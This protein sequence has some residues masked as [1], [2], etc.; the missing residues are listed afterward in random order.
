MRLST[1]ARRLLAGLLPGVLLLSASVALSGTAAA[2]DTTVSSDTLR[3]GWDQN[4]PGLAPSSVTAADFGQ[5]FSTPVNGQVYAQPI[6][7]AGTVITV[8]ENNWIYGMNAA[9]GAITWSRS[10]GAPWPASAIGCGDL[11]PNIGI[12]ST[13]VYDPASNSVF[14]IA[15]VNDGPDVNNPHFYLHSVNPATGVER[16][17]WPVTIQGSPTNSPGNPF[18][19]K[20]A[21]Q[22]PGLLLLGGV[23]YAGFASHCDYGPYA[24]YVAGFSTTTPTMT[25]LWS[26]EAGS[27]SGMAGIW[28]S[29]GG[30]VSDGPGRILLTTGNG[31]SPAPGP[32]TS[33]PGNLGES[34]VRL[35]VNSD[36]SLTAKDFFSP[37]NNAMLDQNDTDF[38][39]GGPMALPAGFGTTAHPNLLVQTGKDGR[40]YL[41]DRDNLGGNAQGPGGTDASVGPPAGPYNGVWGHPAFWGGDGGYVYQ[42]ENAG[43]L[44]AFKYGVNGSGLPVLSSA[45][46]SASTFGYTSG[47]P[48]V[49]STGTTSGSAVVWVVYSDGS[50]GANGQLRAYNAVP[51]NGQLTLLYS[52]PIGTASKFAVPGTDGNRVYV[53]TRDGNVYGFGQ[54]TTAALTGSPT[55]FGNVAVKS[56]ANA[57]VTVTATRTVT[58]SA[59]TASAPFG[60]T[61][62]ALPVTLTSG[63][64]LSVPV[65]FTPTAAG[66]ANGTLSFTTNS[67]TVPFDLH[68][69][70][71]Q[72]GLGATP[73][74]LPFGTV[75]TG[76]N[77]ALSVSIANT[78]T[79]PVTITGSTAPTAPFTVTGLP[80]NGST[81]AAGA[82]VSVTVTYAPTAVGN[83]SGS[84]VVASSAGSVT[85]PLTGTAVAGASHLT[86]TPN[87]V[88]FGSVALGQSATQIFDIAN[89]GNI[90]LT[91]TKAAPPVGVFNTTTP[92]SEGQKLAPGD[93]IQQSVTFSPTTAGAQ[94][95]VYSITG[96]DGQ[97]AIAV[98]LTGTGA[99]SGIGTTNI[100]AGEPATASGTQSGYPAGNATDADVNSYWESVNNAFPQWLQVDLGAANTVGKVTLQV[101]PATA[102]TT[103]TQTLSILGST[104]GTNFT[105]LVPST[106]Y[107]FNPAT[108]N[109]VD[110]LFGPSTVRYLRLSF[111]ANTG[112]PAGQISSFE[113]F[114]TISGTGPATL[115]TSPASLTFAATPVQNNSDWQTVTVT[116]TG[117][118][119]ATLSSIATSGDFTV[120]STCGT[121]LAPGA[122]CVAVVT[123]YPTAAGTRTGA[124]TITGNAT[125]SPTTV[126]LSG[127][128]IATGSA[129]LSANPVSMA[130]ASTTVGSVSAAST[131]TITNTGTVSASVSAVAATAQF[132][133]TNNCA[134][135]APGSSCTVNVTFNPT[136]AGNVTGSLTVTSNATNSPLTVAL[137]GTGTGNTNPTNLAPAGT[138]SA[139]NYT[140]TYAPGNANDNNTSTY[141]EGTNGVWPTTLTCNLGA[142]HSL[143][144]LVIDLPPATAWNTRTQ[145]LSVLGS[146]N[147]SSYTTL[148]GSATYTFNPATG[149]TVTISLPTG[150][151]AQYV[152]L[153]FTAN[154]VQNGAQASEFQVWGN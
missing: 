96:D 20:T 48:V 53:G 22:R 138:M 137:S 154:S 3:T 27:S 85:V 101:P 23:V 124:L 56:T 5:L 57:T 33:P 41:L 43:Y 18:N 46:T 84:L 90:T 6:V 70:G 77:A 126:A 89:T 15:K 117:T 149:N 109:S 100:A 13:P 14:F 105:V 93:I 147:G 11:T 12:T 40:V 132:A 52:A 67:G 120:G 65:Q 31:V 141:W 32:G 58:I 2:D 66:G 44:R 38:G 129:T 9:T 59:I 82:S 71:T 116:N 69:I 108:G 75:S 99:T 81:L 150:T 102:W 92:I 37:S 107:T 114:P 131:V 21:A 16:A 87:P 39:S 119:P 51:V 1:R 60:V 146:S 134:S 111:T 121:S 25:T 133:Q 112:W 86:I 153:S 42:V 152:Q 151:T 64:T 125:N 142:S 97:G 98:Q 24:G 68:G 4:E 143:S 45:G 80:A 145:T 144:S 122:N 95:A 7:V 127:S 118:G 103:R 78:G 28:Q 73:A 130:F 128:G 26:T 47:S 50:T 74:S 148:V 123:F 135:L 62:P 115:S 63:G 30:L 140:Q 29:G 104:D 55:D 54:P 113:V 83:Q 35:Q 34:V 106:G 94:S 88:A 76:G 49:T 136:G 10:V 17:G 91:I 61:A 79:S 110:I 72:A 36:G 8:T 19:P 139:S